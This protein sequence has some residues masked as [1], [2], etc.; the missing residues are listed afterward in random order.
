[1][2]ANDSL[3]I[4]GSGVID[5]RLASWSQS[6][7]EIAIPTIEDMYASLAGLPSEGRE[8]RTAIAVVM[9]I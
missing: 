6:C 5:F 7:H 3:D 9:Y 8:E 4:V 1:V 2:R